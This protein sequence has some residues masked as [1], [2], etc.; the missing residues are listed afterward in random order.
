MNI[1]L[2]NLQRTLLIFTLL[3]LLQACGGGS[4][5]GGNEDKTAGTVSLTSLDTGGEI[6][7]TVDI[8]WTNT[9]ANRSSVVIELSN[10][11]GVTFES[12]EDQIIPDS[13]SYSFDSSTVFDC[14][15][16]RIRI[17]A[18]DVVGNV[19]DPV[20]SSQ[21]FIINN[22]P[23]VLGSALYFDNDNNGFDAGD[24]ITIPFD[25]PI[26]LNATVA[27]DAFYVPVLGD[28]IG[29]FSTMKLGN[30][31]N[32][33]II[34]VNQ[35][36][37]IDTNFHLHV[38]GNFD[39]NKY[40]RT[41][42]SGL[43]IL[44]NLPGDII[45]SKDTLYTAEPIGDGI[46][47][48]PTFGIKKVSGS[49][50]SGI[51]LA[52]T[53]AI[54]LGYLDSDATLD[55]IVINTNSVPSVYSGDGDGTF[56]EIVNPT[57]LG[58]ATNTSVALGDINGDKNIDVIVGNSAGSIIYTNN[59]AGVMALSSTLTDTNTKSV[60]LVDI[61]GDTDLDII[62]GNNGANEV[63]E[64]T[65]LNSGSFTSTSQT[66]GSY[67]TQSIT[68]AD[69]DNDG[70]QDIITANVAQSNR[71]YLNNGSG[72][73]TDSGQTLGST[74][75]DSYSV[76]VGD[77]DGD[78]DIDIVIGNKSDQAN[79]LFLNNGSGIFTV[80]TQ[81]L[82]NDLA[83]DLALFDIDGDEDLD[84]LVVNS[85]RPNQVFFNTGS[86]I[87]DNSG[88][89]LQQSSVTGA[90]TNIAVGDLDQDG[91]LD[92]IEARD[93]LVT[94]VGW[95]N[96][97]KFR[98]NFVDSS[99]NIGSND[100]QGIAVGDL[101]GDGFYDLF[102]ANSNQPNLVWFSDDKFQFTDSNQALGN[103][104]ST[105]VVLG[106]IDNDG[107]LDAI[108]GNK[109]Q[110]NKVW[111]NNG[112]GVFSEIQDLG[113]FATAALVL[114]DIDN[115]DDL[116]LITANAG[117]ANRVYLNNGSGVFTNDTS[118]TGLAAVT[119]VTLA[120]VVGDLNGD[121]APDLV[122]GNT[123]SNSIVWYNDGNGIFTQAKTLSILTSRS[124][125]LGDVDDDGDLDV[126]SGNFGN[127]QIWLNGTNTYIDL[128]T[129]TGKNTTA[130]ALVDIENDGDLD[131][132]ETNLGS[133]GD[134]NRL[135]LSRGTTSFTLPQDI[136]ATETTATTS[137][138][139]VD[140]DSDGDL[141]YITG[142]SGIEPNRVWLNDN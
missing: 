57:T 97:S 120:L 101:N 125:A 136:T 48:A 73:Y 108:V 59:T 36:A 141:D 28:E 33:V 22:V 5:V 65:A 79:E 107:D 129:T 84:L 109:A 83:I 27:S 43:D 103:S 34:T 61:D 132:L 128:T 77:V 112:S 4:S 60:A 19:S 71:V 52:S 75:T 138:A 130:I 118:Q 42:P 113:T 140:L 95:I 47:I 37:G 96:S 21:D 94:D 55:A 20:V 110:A 56:T 135:S 89:L 117:T 131:L 11:S 98:V 134:I 68:F 53:V 2:H 121:N 124:L 16:C 58:N 76:T 39:A 25:K 14:R 127:N 70:D 67:N 40:N 99:Q 10:D 6:V 41:A 133:P 91:D 44:D 13:G 17:T 1:L 114:S 111:R 51:P 82:G 139:I 80:S 100:T 45:F 24:T 137:M 3:F 15:T 85:S 63:W 8:T 104:D 30:N 50:F 119:N 66:L 54:A 9:E 93:N 105:S 12:I 74:T 64:N 31:S 26:E 90:T 38:S 126:L 87:F 32:E 142:N 49:P 88:Q 69:I 62:M 78:N 115:D 116:D 106:D 123:G 122:T 18:T 86:G 92:F 29:P 35:V 46:D 81:S 102:T 7:G 23:Q 72:T